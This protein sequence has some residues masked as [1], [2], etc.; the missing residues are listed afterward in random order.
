MV[1]MCGG[2]SS[3]QPASTSNASFGMHGVQGNVESNVWL[4]S[5]NEQL[6]T[7]FCFLLQKV[8]QCTVGPHAFKRHVWYFTPTGNVEG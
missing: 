3:L 5:G 8:V 2:L 6:N 1:L 7:M 4:S